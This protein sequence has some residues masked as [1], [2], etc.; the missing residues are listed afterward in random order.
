MFSLTT[1]QA[2]DYISGSKCESVEWLQL[3]YDVKFNIYDSK[4]KLP[5]F[6]QLVAVAIKNYETTVSVPDMLQCK[7]ALEHL[8]FIFHHW[9]LFVL[10]T[11]CFRTLV[12]LG[13]IPVAFVG[14]NHTHCNPTVPE[15]LL[16]KC[17]QMYICNWYFTLVTFCFWQ[18]NWSYYTTGCFLLKGAACFR[19]W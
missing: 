19:N 1:N 4:C 10:D 5:K 15:M 11:A 18:L 8:H 7:C 9:L 3:W 17:S 14:F 2:V 6:L 13:E 12:I 16:C